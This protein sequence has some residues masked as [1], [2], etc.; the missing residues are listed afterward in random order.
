ML[1]DVCKSA[2]RP[3]SLD[4]SI[5]KEEPNPIPELIE[6]HPELRLIVFNGKKAAQL[7]EKYFS[8]LDIAKMTMLSTSP[9]NASFS[10]EDKLISWAR[11]MEYLD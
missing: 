10:V 1:W 5:K 9:A 8:Q 2:F 3:G 6:S 4:S 7:F 11:M